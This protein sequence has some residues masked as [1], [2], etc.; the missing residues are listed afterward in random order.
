MAARGIF[1]LC[2]LVMIC[3]ATLDVDVDR[4]LILVNF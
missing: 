2:L 4:K 1:V 3:D